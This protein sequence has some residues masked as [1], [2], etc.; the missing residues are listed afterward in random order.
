MRNSRASPISSR[1]LW[2]TAD[3][4]DFFLHPAAV[5]SALILALLVVSIPIGIVYT[6]LNRPARIARIE[7]ARRRARFARHA[8]GA[9]R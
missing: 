1:I 3:M 5:E 9:R 8:P 2:R 6:I 7:R 4:R